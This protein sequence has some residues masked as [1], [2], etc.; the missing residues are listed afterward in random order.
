[1]SG[2]TPT[3]DEVRHYWVVQ[4]VK[5]RSRRAERAAEFDRWLAE[6]RAKAWDEGANSTILVNWHCCR[7]RAFALAISNQPDNPYREGKA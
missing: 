4:G 6:V 2:Y 5:R 1:M 7:R 3:T